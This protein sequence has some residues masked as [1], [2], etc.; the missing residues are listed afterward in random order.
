MPQT[1]KKHLFIKYCRHL[2][3]S[4]GWFSVFS[5]CDFSAINVWVSD[6]KLLNQEIKQK[7]NKVFNFLHFFSLFTLN[8]TLNWNT[9]INHCIIMCRFIFKRYNLY[10]WQLI[11]MMRIADFDGVTAATTTP[12]AAV[13]KLDQLWIVVLCPRTMTTMPRNQ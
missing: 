11:N 13:W 9:R 2:N 1:T 12:S 5:F 8:P 7:S 4:L 10:S 3:H 6:V